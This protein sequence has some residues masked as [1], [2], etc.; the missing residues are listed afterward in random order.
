[1]Q[2]EA[3]DRGQ[4]LLIGWPLAGGAAPQCDR[5]DAL[6]TCDLAREGAQRGKAR[7]P[8]RDAHSAAGVHDVEH[9]RQL[10]QVVVRWDGQP[11]LEEPLGLLRIGQPAVVGS[12]VSGCIPNLDSISACITSQM[13]S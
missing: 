11:L 6:H 4:Q 13:Q 10:E 1:M 9:V 8:L 7:L 12:A 2:T 3:R 5:R